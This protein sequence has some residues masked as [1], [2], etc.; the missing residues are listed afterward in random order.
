MKKKE[1]VVEVPA[2]ASIEAGAS[3]GTLFEEVSETIRQQEP[4][5]AS[6]VSTESSRGGD[7]VVQ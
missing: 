3:T 4:E 5:P 6:E 7:A 1:E 2:D